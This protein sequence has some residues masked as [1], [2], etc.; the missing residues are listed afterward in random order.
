[1]T[2]RQRLEQVFR[3]DMVDVVPFAL[4]GWRI[5][6]CADERRLRNDGMAVLDSAPVYRSRSPHVEVE[7]HSYQHEGIGYQRRVIKTPVGSLTSVHRPLGGPQVE[8]TTWMMEPPFKSPDDYA[9][10]EF[11]VSDRSYEP[12]YDA[13]DAAEAAMGDEAFFKTGAPGCAL[14]TVLYSFMGPERFA[15]EW[16]ERRDRVLQLCAAMEANERVIY[17]IVAASP[18][19]LVQCGGNYAPEM[20][21]K[22]RLVEHVLPHWEAAAAVLHEGGK[23]LGCHLD[24]NNAHWAAEVADAPLDWIEAFSPAPDTDMSL[25]QARAAWPGKT[26]FI[27]FP[28]A[29]HLQPAEEIAATTRQLLHEAAPGDRFVVGITE[30]VPEQR[31]RESFRT[32]LDTLNEE[33]RL[34]LPL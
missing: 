17:E 12:C 6:Q 27:N 3:G 31:W 32:I 2:P 15:T 10:L 16:A 24:A 26:L 13:F 14:H 18:A 11:M 23:Q 28:S 25:A 22:E 30:N 1:V 33:G 34:P 5:P 4:K 21:G 7:T 19:L 29:V 20:L 9:V 8:R